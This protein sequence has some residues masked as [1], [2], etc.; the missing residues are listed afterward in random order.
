MPRR[1]HVEITRRAERDILAVFEHIAEENEKTSMDWISEVERQIK[2]LERFP[3]RCSV[4]PESTELEREYRHLIY[5]NY[6]TIF[7]ITGSSVIIL[8]VI[9]GSQLLDLQVLK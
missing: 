6:R 1:Y 8:R 3:K 2:T 5:G 9:H 4:I 7:R